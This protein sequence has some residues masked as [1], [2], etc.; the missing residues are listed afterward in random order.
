MVVAPPLSTEC[1]TQSA[2]QLERALHLQELAVVSQRRTKRGGEETHPASDEGAGTLMTVIA[3]YKAA[4]EFTR[5]APTSRRAYLIYIK[6]IE[7]AFG[8]S[9][10][11][12][13]RGYF[14]S[15]QVKS[16]ALEQRISSICRAS[17]SALTFRASIFDASGCCFSSSSMR[18]LNE[19][20]SR[21]RRSISA[22]FLTDTTGFQTLCAGMMRSPAWSRLREPNSWPE[23]EA[24]LARV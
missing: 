15:K 1:R 3:E 2:L 6:L 22:S 23:M 7:D 21:R 10:I 14:A 19:A 5:L 9:R 13:V 17:K 18:S 16:F 4:P 12:A 20:S 11:A 24:L 8:I